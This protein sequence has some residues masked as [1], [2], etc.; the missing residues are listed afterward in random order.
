M[1]RGD[2][3]IY[4]RTP[5]LK[6]RVIQRGEGKRCQGKKRGN[7]KFCIAFLKKTIF[8]RNRGEDGGFHREI[9]KERERVAGFDNATPFTVG[10]C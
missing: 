3:P 7:T 2:T 4:N 1:K 9:C 5:C 10:P 6:R 8:A